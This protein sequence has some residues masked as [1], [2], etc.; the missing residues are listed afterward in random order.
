LLHILGC[1]RVIPPIAK[2]TADQTKSR[3]SGSQE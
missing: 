3:I 2:R 1:Y